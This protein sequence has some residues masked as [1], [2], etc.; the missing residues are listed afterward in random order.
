MFERISGR[1]R[2]VVVAG[3]L[4]APALIVTAGAQPASADGPGVG[5]PWVV[6]LG[7]SAISGEAGRWAGNTN[8][9]YTKVD[10]LGSDAYYDNASRTAEQIP[11]CHRSESAAI[12]I[13]GGVSSLNLA[14]SGAQTSTH[15]GGDT[16]FKP[17]LDF[18][19]GAY[20][21]GQ[22]LALQ[23]FASTHNVK[24]VS[25]LIGANDYG[26]ADILQTCFL[27]WYF[28]PSWWRDYCN[29]DADIVARFTSSNIAAKT[30]AIKGGLLNV[31]QA[32]TNAGYSDSSYTIMVH[33]YWSPIP[34]GSGNRYPETGY[35][36]QTIGGC[37]MWNRDADW[38]NDTVVPTFNSSVRNAATQTGLTNIKVLDLTSS[39]NGRRLCE[40]TV[41][42]LEEV[43]VSSWT[44]R[45]AVDK[46]EWVN[47]LRT[48][49]TIS[50]P[51]QI[52]E[53]VHANYWGQLAMRSCMRLA[54]NGGSP[55]AGSCVR[56]S[57]G[58]TSLGEPKMALQ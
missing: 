24:M 28:S 56:A 27:D 49:S 54:Y 16:D 6:S 35:T 52:Q 47:Q 22:A 25:V 7:D 43:G 4:L 33:T 45:K 48:T 17:G 44:S 51:Y 9:S 36:R 37:G 50:G 2:A 31:R 11:G 23:E 1:G 46:T 15:G 40:N 10:A 32:M 18:Y 5:S 53:S 12:H 30:A 3:A 34:R 29:D 42:L 58:L 39:L 26:F 13:G 55:R 19:N 38:A 57:T 8:D 21:K 41:G 20:G 14:C